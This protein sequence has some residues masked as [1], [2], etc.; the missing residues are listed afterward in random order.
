MFG[1]RPILLLISLSHSVAVGS[2][3]LIGHW[4]FEHGQERTDLTGNF[5]D[6]ALSDGNSFV[7]GSLLCRS[8]GGNSTQAS[9][10]NGRSTFLGPA[11]VNKTFVVWL[12]LESLD[13]TDQ[14]WSLESYSN[15]TIPIGNVDL[16][17]V[18]FNATDSTWFTTRAL[19]KA[20]DW[21]RIPMN[22]SSINTLIQLAFTYR[23]M[24]DE[25]MTVTGFRDGELIGE[26][27]IKVLNS[28]SL[29]TSTRRQMMFGSSK[30]L[31][32][33]T[34]YEAR[35][36]ASALN[37]TEL[38]SL[39]LVACD[40]SIPTSR[41]KGRWLVNDNNSD[42]GL[43]TAFDVS[44]NNRSGNYEL[45]AG[46]PPAWHIAE[47]TSSYGPRRYLSL[48]NTAITVPH[49]FEID[50]SDFLVSLWARPRCRRCPLL[51]Q[52]F[53]C[54]SGIFW[55]L[56]LPNE[57]ETVKFEVGNGAMMSQVSTNKT[58]DHSWY[59]FECIRIGK[60]LTLRIDG[61]V[62]AQV[63]ASGIAEL[64][65]LN[66]LMIGAWENSMCK[67]IGKFYTGDIAE[68]TLS[69]DR[70]PFLQCAPSD[71]GT[72]AS[73]WIMPTATTKIPSSMTISENGVAAPGDDQ[74]LAIGIGVGVSVGVALIIVLA[75]TI[76]CISKRSKVK[77]QASGQYRQTA[78]V[79]GD[80]AA[81]TSMSSEYASASILSNQYQNQSQFIYSEPAEVRL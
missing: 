74:Q 28:I 38:A 50:T 2:L 25:S 72:T 71:S 3:P 56:W 61:V 62:Q 13:A 9:T 57:T 47:T 64:R 21:K 60:T 73:T 7:G 29:S 27:T 78:T 4:T 43:M 33:A 5:P 31:L 11:I 6:L 8:G 15:H 42:I 67:N 37:V 58:L 46:F 75:I 32:H 39:R 26:H 44:G 16:D 24:A 41:P 51:G 68:V 54:G 45:M 70:L 66:D 14:L 36:Y 65:K 19:G 34:I 59:F 49:S 40:G 30:G 22:A 55:N 10:G 76:A 53:G 63:N 79:A 17:A 69:I 20:L 1:W 23:M 81:R 12:A 18:Y 77:D 80:A 52:R 48:A 35:L